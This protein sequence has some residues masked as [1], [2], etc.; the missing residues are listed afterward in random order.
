MSAIPPG[1]VRAALN[2]RR[3]VALL[4]LSVAVMASRGGSAQATSSTDALTYFKNYFVTGDYVVGG[5]GLRGRGVNGIATGTI[6][7]GPN[8]VPA[9]ADVLAAFLYWQEVA[10]DSES[11]TVGATF[12]GN[13]LTSVSGSLAKTISPDGGTAPCWS[14]GGGTGSSGGSKRTFTYR[15]DVLRF[16]DVGTNGK[17]IVN[18]NHAVQLADSGSNGNGVPLA[19]GAS[20]LVIYRDPN[21]STP[22][23]SIAIYDGGYT[24][25]QGHESMSQTIRGFYQLPTNPDGTQKASVADRITHIVGSGQPNKPERL[26]FNGLSSVTVSPF[27]GAAGDSWDNFTLFPASAG[28][29]FGFDSDGAQYATT[30]VDHAG[31]SS[32]DC[33]TWGAIVYRT[34]VK[35]TDAD[36][37]LDLW[38]SSTTP[39][40]DPSGEVLPNLAA[41]GASPTEKDFFVEVGYMKTDGPLSYGGA[42]PKPAHT[43]LPDPRALQSIAEATNAQ[44]IRAHFDIGG[45]YQAPNIDPATGLPYPALPSIPTC[46]SA[47]EWRCAIVPAS[48]ARGGE[49]VDETV[50]V[51]PP[52][53]SKP[54][55][56]QFSTYPGTVG[57]KTGF[58][59]I[60][61]ERF[62]NNRKDM[63]HYVLFAHALGLPKSADETSLDFHVPRTNTGVADLP[64]GDAMI[65]LGAFD[66]ISGRPVG[67]PFMQASTLLHELGHNFWRR[68]GGEFLQPNCKPNYL[69]VMN[70]MFQ[71][72]G[73]LDNAGV[74]HVDLSGQALDPLSEAAL[75]NLNPSPAYRTAWYAPTGSGTFGPA[76][77]KHCDGSALSPTEIVAG[78]SMVR[79]DGTSVTTDINWN[80]NPL[81]STFN[82]DVNFD[83][84]VN[85]V[86]SGGVAAEGHGLV[87]TGS[88]DWLNL[89]LNQ[90]GSRRNI[91]ALYLDVTSSGCSVSAPCLAIGPMSLSLGQGDLGQGD[92]GQGDLG[93]GDLGQ[94]DL[95]QGDLGQG[96]LGRGT[97]GQGDLGQGD[98][99]QGDLGQGDLGVG[100]PGEPTGEL[101]FGIA[102]ALG[103][104][105]PNE[106]RAQRTPISSL[107][108]RV[109]I[110]WKP[111]NVGV[112]TKF[113]IYRMYVGP[114]VP[115]ASWS[116]S[117][118]V[119]AAV[120]AVSGQ[121]DYFSFDDTELPDNQ[122]FV[123][124]VVAEYDDG[125]DLDLLP[126]LSAPSAL[127]DS[128]RITAVNAAPSGVANAYTVNQGASLTIAAR[129]V[130]SNDTDIDSPANPLNTVIVS[131]PL[132]GSL[133]LNGNGGFTYTPNP[134]FSGTDSFTYKANDGTFTYT[135]SDGVAHAVAMSP[136][137][138]TVTVSITVTPVGYVFV[139]VQNAPPS[140]NKTFKA[141]S[142]VPMQWQYK[143]GSTVVDSSLVRFAVTVTGPIPSTQARSITNTDPGSSSFRYDASTKTWSFNLQTKE[144]TGASYPAGTYNVQVTT[145]LP[146]FLPSPIFQIKLVK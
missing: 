15:A 27:V 87:L 23:N 30:T 68:H 113:W 20:L 97:L 25:D 14:S 77:T 110:D 9:G 52:D 47:W 100:G 4:A 106:V 69:S 34:E 93:Q 114:A 45:S 107:P 13:P 42:P 146:N 65:T 73:L 92:L 138:N 51:C 7:M 5:V 37:L 63:F 36:G 105:P 26:L 103:R 124:F 95:G 115:A 80:P 137:S 112:A 44:G 53:A 109:R 33:L 134:L 38:E 60:R 1:A 102:L 122:Q 32:F 40:H 6:D 50:T 120:S 57:W 8:A 31:S 22:L 43:H 119:G 54:W 84:K 82:Q 49:S 139:N 16:L 96:D 19:L 123:Y 17:F 59:F 61:D 70:Y 125:P 90:V 131:G 67:T 140:G 72:R 58:R 81:G 29:T 85:D 126:D 130:L 11:G 143:N 75:L 66:D 118:L 35:D 144:T 98:L 41:M 76:A 71:L 142:A 24:M 117:A 128:A 116:T 78:T 64:G 133:S 21:P 46:Q 141:G 55:V 121:T 74:P 48:V 99:G 135:G 101:D 56:C 145:S 129:G 83:G 94:G 104:T 18:G 91:G 86:D 2:S 88:N 62:D 10:T 79:V 108:H 136:D 28:S 39:L 3:I 89:R 132:N 12:K 127:S 111:T